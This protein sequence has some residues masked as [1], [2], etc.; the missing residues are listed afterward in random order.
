MTIYAGPMTMHKTVA[1]AAVS[2]LALLGLSGCSSEPDYCDQLDATEEAFNELAETSIISEGTDTLTQ[3]YDAFAAEVNSL[4]DAA[5][6]EFSEETTAVEESLDQLNSALQSAANLDLGTAAEQLGPSLE[7]V[8]ESAEALF[9]S[10]TTEC[11]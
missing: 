9:T 11:S 1:I 8:S 6:D 5:G 2:S 7:A 3:R 4:T 10:V